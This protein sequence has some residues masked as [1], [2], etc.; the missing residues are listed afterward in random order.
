LNITNEKIYDLL[1]KVVGNISIIENKIQE[2]ETE[3]KFI[4]KILVQKEDAGGK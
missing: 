1:C 2:L 4:K 3:I